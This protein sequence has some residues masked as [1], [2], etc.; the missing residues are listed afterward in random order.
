MDKAIKDLAISNLLKYGVIVLYPF[1]IL[2]TATERFIGVGL[3][4]L[5]ALGI[6]I[7]SVVY[8]WKFILKVLKN[9]K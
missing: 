2:L 5:I 1:I 4:G 7:V 3:L 8:E 9:V 6:M